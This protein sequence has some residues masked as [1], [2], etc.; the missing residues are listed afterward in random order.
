[1]VSSQLLCL[2]LCGIQIIIIL[3]LIFYHS[4]GFKENGIVIGCRKNSNYDSLFNIG[5]KHAT[6]KVYTHHYEKLYEKYLSRYR[7]TSVRLLEIGLGLG[8][9]HLLNFT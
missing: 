2:L 5:M 9:A 6:D 4:N 1:M 8:V 3:G 7:H